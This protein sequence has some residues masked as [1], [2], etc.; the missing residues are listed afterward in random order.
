MF[1]TSIF[2]L[3][4]LLLFSLLLFCCKSDRPPI[5]KKTP[6]KEIVV[7]P[8]KISKINK[9][10]FYFENSLSMNGYLNGDNFQQTVR[11][12]LLNVDQDSLS[13]YFVNTKEYTQ[14]NLKKKIADKKI[15]TSG[16]GNSDHKFIFTNAIKKAKG[17]NLSIVITDGIYSM[18]DGNISLVEIDIE[19]AFK[20]AL[21]QNELETVVLKM[22][23]NFKGRYY[24]ESCKKKGGTQIDQVRPYYI[25]LFGNKKVI[26][27]ALNEIVVIEDLEG[28]DEQARFLIT[29]DLKINYSVLTKGEEKQGEYIV[30]RSSKLYNVKEIEGAEKFTKSGLLLK[31]RYLQFGVAV[32]YSTLSIPSNYLI[33]PINYSIENN[34]GYKVDE[35]KTVED[36]SKNSQTYKWIQDLNKKGNMNY[37]HVLVVKAKS[38]LY[39]DL[40]VNLEMNFPSWISKTGSENDCE[41]KDDSSTTFAFDRLMNGISKAYKKVNNRNNFFELKINIKP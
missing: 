22:T 23:S 2:L 6:V 27:K 25:L 3:F 32:D 7:Q 16:I 35:I 31:N 10:N 38:D 5:N 33:N 19:D 14:T 1:K 34:T 11:R 9:V 29:K 41:I 18:K 4:S 24:S 28:F 17:N 13:T 8:H 26:D 30:K 20:K 39:G 40:K 12:I 37:T 15:A 36:L 21:K